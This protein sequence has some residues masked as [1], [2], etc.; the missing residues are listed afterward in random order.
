MTW[1]DHQNQ[2][3]PPDTHENPTQPPVRHLL[4]SRPPTPVSIVKRSISRAILLC[5]HTCAVF[6][7]TDFTSFC[8]HFLIDMTS[9]WHHLY[10]LPPSNRTSPQLFVTRK[11]LPNFLWSSKP[12]H[13][14]LQTLRH[15]LK[16][17]WFRCLE[18]LRRKTNMTW[19]L[20]IQDAAA[21]RPGAKQ[22]PDLNQG[23]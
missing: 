12:I 23:R 6:T 13:E 22:R 5:V 16:V 2:R 19:S 7:T 8:C 11:Y 4:P 14:P 15:R 10:F 21:R 18:L 20:L 3:I 17:V 1:F 9:N